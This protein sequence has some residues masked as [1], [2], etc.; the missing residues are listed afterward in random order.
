MG[1]RP[2]D[3][4]SV[5][6]DGIGDLGGGIGHDVIAR[7]QQAGPLGGLVAEQ[8]ADA[9]GPVTFLEKVQVLDPVDVDQVARTCEPQLE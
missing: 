8:R 9:K 5:A 6:D 2:R 4:P 7:G 3:G 1:D